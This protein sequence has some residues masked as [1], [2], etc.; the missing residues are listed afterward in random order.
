MQE[1]GITSGSRAVGEHIAFMG[2]GRLMEDRVVNMV[3]A[4]FLRL[5]IPYVSMVDGGYTAFHEALGP[6]E[7]NRLLVSHEE[8]FCFVC[9]AN[10]GRQAIRMAHKSTPPST[11]ALQS[12]TLN[13]APITQP[14]GS[15]ISK[16]SNLLKKTPV[17]PAVTSQPTVPSTSVRS[18]T[19][20]VSYRNTAAVFSIDDNDDDDDDDES[21][22]FALRLNPPTQVKV[23]VQRK[24][25]TSVVTSLET[26]L[27]GQ[28]IGFQECRKM[29]GVNDSFDCMLLGADEIPSHRGVILVLE[30]SMIV[31]REREK[32]MFEVLGNFVQKAFMKKT[33]ASTARA[34]SSSTSD[35]PLDGVIEVSFPMERLTRITSKKLTPEI[36][37]FHCFQPGMPPDVIRLRIAKA[38][39]AVKTIKTAVFNCNGIS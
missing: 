18:A 20:A 2:S 19:K 16:F 7:F 35:R 11:T 29:P 1:C 37:T 27:P 30:K 25:Q 26:C 14:L 15:V 21:P 31:V 28:L 39:E 32:P 24:G 23:P 10:R 33:P 4:C 5:N 9:A 34:T 17:I 8:D 3:I 38:G 6:L 13:T 36:I 12:T 22:D